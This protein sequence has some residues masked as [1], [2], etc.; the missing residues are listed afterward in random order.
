MKNIRTNLSTEEMV[1]FIKGRL[2]I[3]FLWKNGS[4]LIGEAYQLAIFLE[5]KGGSKF[6][7]FQLNG[8]FHVVIRTHKNRAVVP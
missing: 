7:H 8:N 5:I 4:K 1:I 6:G 3:I 2:K